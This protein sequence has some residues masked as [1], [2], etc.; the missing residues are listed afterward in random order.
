MKPLIILL[1]ISASIH[2]FAEREW[3]NVSYFERHDIKARIN[4]Y[5]PPV[6]V[7]WLAIPTNIP[8]ELGKKLEGIVS[9]PSYAHDNFESWYMSYTN[10][11]TERLFE[12]IQSK[13]FLKNEFL[14]FPSADEVK[15]SYPQIRYRNYL[16]SVD[17]LVDNQIFTYVVF[18]SSESPLTKFPNLNELIKQNKIG[19]TALVQKDET[20]KYYAKSELFSGKFFN[21]WKNLTSIINILEAG[22][23]YHSIAEAGLAPFDPPE[24]FKVDSIRERYDGE[25]LFQYPEPDA[26]LAELRAQELAGEPVA[27]MAETGACAERHHDAIDSLAL[28]LTALYA[29]IVTYLWRRRRA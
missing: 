22:Y 16:W 17:Y 5:D 4:I 18:S 12:E 1:F 20:W 28:K 3:H 15:S 26:R 13:E 27:L 7:D 2:L 25:T 10:F 11:S 8:N 21:Q 24:R 23:C 14:H 6:V 19:A 9:R 29:L